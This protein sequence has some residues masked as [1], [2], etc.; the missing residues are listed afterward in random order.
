MKV[1][2]LISV[3]VLGLALL[4]KNEICE[5]AEQSLDGYLVD[6]K[7]MASVLGDPHPEDFIKHHTKDCSLMLNCKKRGYAIYTKR[8]W[9]ML[10]KH[11][12]KLAIS[13]L[14]KSMRRNS[15]YVRGF[16]SI[17]GEV[18]R[19]KKLEEIDEPVNQDAATEG[20]GET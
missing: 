17:K 20:S 6:R 11:G 9:L 1:T 7:C 5:A 12:N 15:F 13:L 10:D 19:A 3:T 14:E 8:R 4:L 18:L 16:G 2:R